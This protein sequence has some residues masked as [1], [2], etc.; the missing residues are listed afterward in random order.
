MKYYNSETQNVIPESWKILV[1]G[2]TSIHGWPIFSKLQKILP[3]PQLFGL[4]PPKLNYLKAD[5]ILSACITDKISLYEIKD[6]FK[7]TH[8]IHCAGVCDLDVCEERPQWAR[9]INV[10]GA[11]ALI[12]VFG[13]SIPI[14]YM[15]TDLVYSGNNPPQKGYSEND[16]PDPIS[17]AGAT[18]AEAETYIQKIKNHCIIR[19]GL[20][21]GNSINGKKGAVDWIES[22]FKKNRPVTLFYD[23]FRSCVYCEE[24]G[25]LAVAVLIKQLKGLYHFGGKKSWSLHDIG[26]YVLKKGNY[27]SDLLNGILR[28]QEKNGPPRIG[29][30]SLNS[31]RIKEFI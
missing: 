13:V 5:N 19:L 27:P 3:P 25:E 18:F 23:E 29:D 8:T 2:I 17:V 21:L 1:T 22:R 10:S 16:A 7:P 30:V 14:F 11:Q 31:T 4:G 24:I 6:S 15:S 26:E 12:D 20:P 28:H 9:T